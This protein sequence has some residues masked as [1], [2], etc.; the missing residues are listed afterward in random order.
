MF[1]VWMMSPEMRPSSAAG[2]SLVMTLRWTKDSPVS[3]S[4]GVLEIHGMG[5][6]GAAKD[7]RADIR[8]GRQFIEEKWIT[9][10]YAGARAAEID[11]AIGTEGGP[12]STEIGVHQDLAGVQCRPRG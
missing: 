2:P 4:S 9:P 8:A 12:A 6:G 3:R 7:Q 5:G 11:G 1:G 10:E